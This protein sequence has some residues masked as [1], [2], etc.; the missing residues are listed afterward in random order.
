M[1]AHAEEFDE[2][3]RARMPLIA[4]SLY[5]AFGDRGKAEDCAQEAFVRAWQRWRSLRGNDPTGW[6]RTVAWRLRIDDWRATGRFEK[7]LAA[8]RAEPRTSEQVG[9]SVALDLL[10]G[11][12][13]PLRSVAVLHYV[14]DLTVADIAEALEVPEG[15]VKSRL[16]RARDALRASLSS[17]GGHADGAAL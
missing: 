4:H 8:V 13:P 7:A 12:S 17:S 6:V 3:Y 10:R 5:L 2:F 1:G 11:L 16:S 14:E 9:D 15:T